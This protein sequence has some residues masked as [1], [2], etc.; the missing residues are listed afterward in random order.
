VLLFELLFGFPFFS[1]CLM[2]KPFPLSAL[3][4]HLVV[5]MDLTPNLRFDLKRS[6]IPYL[7]LLIGQ[8]AFLGPGSS[9]FTVGHPLKKNLPFFPF[10]PEKVGAKISFTFISFFFSRLSENDQ[11]R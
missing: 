1:F 9:L 3:P 11:K 4:F 6:S 2:F 8:S 5:E 7:F 10:P